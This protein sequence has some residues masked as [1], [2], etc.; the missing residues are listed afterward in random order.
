MQASELHWHIS[1]QI[2]ILDEAA[3]SSKD[4][5]YG[6]VGVKY[7]FAVE[8]RDTGRYGFLLPAAQIVP[9]GE[10]MFASLQTLANT[11]VDYGQKK[12][13]IHKT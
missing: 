5:A 12:T 4:W 9:T 13:Y 3:G 11:M 8:L 2:T 7:S 6:S 10:E 1:Y